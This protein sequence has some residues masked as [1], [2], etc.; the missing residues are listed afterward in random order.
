MVTPGADNAQDANEAF[1]HGME[2]RDKHRWK[3][4]ALCFE[5]AASLVPDWAEAWFWL[6][7]TRDNRGDEPAAI[8]AYRRAIDLG[9]EPQERLAQAWTW[10]ASSL[11]KTSQH[12]AAL[13][14]IEVAERLGGYDP[15]QEF[16]TIAQAV[17]RRSQRERVLR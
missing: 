9:L 15:R 6:A 12:T 8:P 14:A 5:R 10:L 13:H 7:V 11:S 16:D 17:R 4:A 3:A 1:Q 2:L